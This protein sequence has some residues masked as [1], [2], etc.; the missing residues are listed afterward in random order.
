MMNIKLV[1]NNKELAQARRIRKKV[2]E[3]EQ[4][5]PHEVN[6]DG[7]DHQAYHA[8]IFEGRKPV[9]YSPLTAR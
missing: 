8:L 4:G 9:A 6:I 1:S 3:D 2:L 7:N 5:F